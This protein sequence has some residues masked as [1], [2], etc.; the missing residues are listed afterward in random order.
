M[1][2]ALGCIDEGFRRCIEFWI[3]VTPLFAHYTWV[4]RVSHARGGPKGG[5]E[6]EAEFDRLHQRYAPMVKKATLYM[7]GFYLKAAQL[8]SVRDDYLPP[9]YLEWT[10]QLQDEVPMVISSEDA[11]AL[12]VEELHLQEAGLASVLYDWQDEPIGTASIGQVYK[13]RL[14]KTGEWIAVKV[15]TPN[16]E[17]LFRADIKCLQMF[18]YFA[19]PWAY[20]NMVEIEKAFRAE[21]DY[22]AEFRNLVAIHD[23]MMPSWGKKVRVPRAVPEVVSRRVL[24]ME[25]LEGEKFVSAVQR[26]LKPL[27]DRE[28]KTVEEYQEEQLALLRSGKRKPET[29]RMLRWKLRL[30]R[31]LSW[32][33]WLRGGCKDKLEQPVDIA[34]S[35]ETLMALHGQQVLQDG[36]FNADPHPGN[37]MLL[38]DGHTLGL[39]DFGQVIRVPLEFRLRLARLIIALSK[40]NPA[41]VARLEAEIGV[42]RKYDKEDVRYRMCSF[43]LDRDTE[44]V[45]QGLN[46]FDLLLWGEE[47]D[48]V[49]S[50]GEGYYMTCRCS[51]TLRSAALAF[52]VQ[53]STAEY[54]RPYAEALL[55]KHGQLS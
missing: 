24:G 3:V 37:V 54:W 20:E 50:Q 52:G 43:W 49:I 40:K 45:T 27:A 34:S 36:C 32:F 31:C 55:K 29:V 39:I 17:R 21:F 15:Q 47:H 22:V 18:T 19:L 48:P 30:Q 25:L 6:R 5:A 53:L 1:L 10:R 42:Q 26:R 38:A 13:A 41:D 44:D 28:G 7:R 8:V 23:N 46:L 4:D 14:T 2:V 16:A 12:V 11:Q 35:F 33:S 9:I 51:V